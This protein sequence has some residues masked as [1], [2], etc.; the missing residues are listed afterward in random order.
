[1]IGE[2]KMKKRL[3]GAGF[4]RASLISGLLFM[5]STPLTAHAPREGAAGNADPS[6]GTLTPACHAAERYI[7]LANAGAFDRMGDLFAEAVDYVGPDMVARTHRADVAKVYSGMTQVFGSN[8]P[9]AQI[10]RLAA[11]GTKEC[12]LEFE[13]FNRIPTQP[14]RSSGVDHF[15]VN[16]AG[17]VIRFR[18]YFAQPL[19]GT[20]KR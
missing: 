20:T 10:L 19:A 17:E 12:F 13:F 4:T 9:Q 11:L 18:P 1:M 2:Q 5:A 8:P 6:P 15:T 14:I 16:D 3:V 7:A